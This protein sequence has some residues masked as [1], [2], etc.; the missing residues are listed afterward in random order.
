ME[1]GGKAGPHKSGAGGQGGRLS[2][3]VSSRS[4]TMHPL[5]RAQQSAT[6]HLDTGAGVVGAG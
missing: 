5:P 6:E 2:P 3:T 4:H 1:A